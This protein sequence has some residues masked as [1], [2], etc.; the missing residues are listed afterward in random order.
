MHWWLNVS[1]PH[2]PKRGLPHGFLKDGLH[3]VLSIAH[4]NFL[5]G[6]DIGGVLFAVHGGYLVWGGLVLWLDL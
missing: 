5:G 3:L 4:H 6:Q 2:L 1:L